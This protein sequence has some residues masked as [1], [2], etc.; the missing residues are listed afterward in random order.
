MMLIKH[1]CSIL[2]V[3]VLG[4]LIAIPVGLMV[5]WTVIAE[6][7][8]EMKAERRALEWLKEHRNK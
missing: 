8:D 4:L 6:T 7:H 2:V 1:I 5:V 3:T